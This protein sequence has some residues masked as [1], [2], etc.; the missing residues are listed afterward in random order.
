MQGMDVDPVVRKYSRLGFIALLLGVT[1]RMAGYYNAVE[2]VSMSRPGG[3]TSFWV[4]GALMELGLV[5]LILGPC[6]IFAAAL[7]DLLNRKSI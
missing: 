5:L 4:I 2:V 3:F 1:A 6:L 7:V